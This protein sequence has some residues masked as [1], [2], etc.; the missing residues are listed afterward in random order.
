MNREFKFRHAN[1]I[2]GV[3]VIGAVVLFVLGIVFTGKSQGW[4]EQRFTLNV[5]FDTAEGSFGLQEGAPVMVRNTVAGRVG[6][7]LPTPDGLMGVTF[8]LKDRFRPFITVDSVAKIK[9][10]FGVAGDSYVDIARGQGAVILDGASIACI[11]DEELLEMAQRMLTDVQTN[12]LPILEK[13]EAI[14]TSVASILDQVD[15][16][17]GVAGAAVGDQQLRD[18][19]KAMVSHVEQ[20]T[21]HAKTTVGQVES[22]M[23]NEVAQVLANAGTL[24]AQ[25]VGLMSNDV[26]LLAGEAVKVQGELTKTL[27]ETRRL[28]RGVQRHWL[29]RKYVEVEPERLPLLPSSLGWRSERG[30]EAGLQEELAAARTADNAVR[31]RRHAYNLAMYALGRDDVK[32]ATALLEEIRFAGRLGGAE[33][34]LPE[35][36]LLEAELSRRAGDYERAAALAESVVSGTRGRDQRPLQA[37]ARILRAAVY[38]EAGNSDAAKAALQEAVQAVKQAEPSPALEAV[39]SGLRAEILVLDGDMAAAAAAFTAQAESFREATAYAGMTDALCR[40]GDLYSRLGMSNSAATHYLRAAVSLAAR[41]LTDEA[42]TVL[43]QA[44]GQAESAGDALLTA[45]I[46]DIRQQLPLK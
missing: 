32:Q 7:V 20:I 19:I 6:P 4:F 39:L 30:D 5:V 14:I 23:S 10:K 22:M 8:V 21:L 24:S 35:E 13:V 15:K 46:E 36:Q 26:P 9:K 17:Q 45:R 3:F 38:A 43:T 44:H 31:I 33:A 29:L 37:E 18:D 1:E 40:A 25:A 2:A 27:S 12:M 16:G 41:D 28:I 34:V 42:A 11:K